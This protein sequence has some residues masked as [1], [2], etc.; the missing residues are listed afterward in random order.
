MAE[1]IAGGMDHDSSEVVV[2]G[3]KAATN[4]ITKKPSN[5]R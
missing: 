1:H 3:S 5:G 4:G 2:T